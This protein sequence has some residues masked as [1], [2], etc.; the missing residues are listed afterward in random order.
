MWDYFKRMIKRSETNKNNVDVREEWEQWGDS[1]KE[2]EDICDPNMILGENKKTR[3]QNFLDI[4][5]VDLS[6]WVFYQGVGVNIQTNKLYFFDS[7]MYNIGGA[8]GSN[9][10][11]HCIDS[12]EKLVDYID[13]ALGNGRIS[14]EEAEGYKELCG[15]NWI[16]I[17]DKCKYEDKVKMLKED[18]ERE[19]KQKII[20]NREEFISEDLGLRFENFNSKTYA[21]SNFQGFRYKSYSMNNGRFVYLRKVSGRYRLLFVHGTSQVPDELVLNEDA[22]KNTLSNKDFTGSRSMTIID[23]FLEEDEIMW[24]LTEF[25]K[26]LSGRALQREYNYK[27][28]IGCYGNFTFLIKPN[29]KDLIKITGNDYLQCRFVYDFIEIIRKVVLK[30]YRFKGNSD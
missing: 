9:D 8:Y 22:I 12:K 5:P 6:P 3:Y 27:E 28:H 18:K 20:I 16:S 11:Y 21:I 2:I 24:I 23:R 30:E 19:E 14:I 4:F 26:K 1:C 15:D 13:R 7:Q 10:S 25:H 17:V 29:C